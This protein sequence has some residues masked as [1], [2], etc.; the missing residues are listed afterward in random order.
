MQVVNLCEKDMDAVIEANERFQD[1]IS[2]NE[3]YKAQNEWTDFVKASEREEENLIKRNDDKTIII[4]KNGKCREIDYTELLYTMNKAGHKIFTE[5]SLLSKMTSAIISLVEEDLKT[6]KTITE[7]K[8]N[9]L[10]RYRMFY[11]VNARY[12]KI[13]LMFNEYIKLDEA[14][15]R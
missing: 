6:F 3:Y 4:Y 7:K 9:Y 15:E 10:I 12:Q 14:I 11:V 2:I 13:E 8:L 1:L 5:T